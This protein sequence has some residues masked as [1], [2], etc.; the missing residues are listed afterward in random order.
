[1][2]KP[3]KKDKILQSAQ[4]LFAEY[5]YA[6]TSM[7]NIAKKADVPSSLIFHH[8]KNK[9]S[10]WTAVKMNI[11]S[12]AHKKT[13][14]L[15]STKLH[16]KIFL[17]KL[18][19]QNIEFFKQNSDI[20]RLINWQRLEQNQ[21]T[22]VKSSDEAQKWQKAI[23]H[24]QKNGQI[25]KELQPTFVVAFIA[26]IVNTIALDIKVLIPKKIDQ[27]LYINFCIERMISALC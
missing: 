27:E 19:E 9:Q 14:T 4:T 21:Q 26:G 1:M 15:P 18:I 7:S 22:N 2:K 6:G 23:E 12:Q 8:F 13:P 17:K 16:L 10:L 3:S 11:V 25:K 5:G 20:I 24:Y